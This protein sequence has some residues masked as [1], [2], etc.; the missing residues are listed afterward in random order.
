MP[1]ERGRYKC[2]RPSQGLKTGKPS[3]QIACMKR[4]LPSLLVPVAL[5]AAEPLPPFEMSIERLDPALD[6]L[7]A[8][9]TKVEK[10]AEG[11][12]WSEGPTWYQG[13]VVFSD[14]PENIAYQWKAGATK[15][16][17]FIQPSGMSTPAEGFREQGSNGLNVDARG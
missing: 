14:V 7:I 15:A 13:S 4:I 10:L 8:P 11:F 3:P 6:A 17:I 9:D 12:N 1:V 2:R 5:F 16:D